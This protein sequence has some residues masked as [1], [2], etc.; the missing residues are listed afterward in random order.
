MQC[1]RL[2]F[3]VHSKQITLRNFIGN[4]KWDL[5]ACSL[6]WL[7]HVCVPR[8]IVRWLG[9]EGVVIGGCSISSTVLGTACCNGIVRAFILE[10][11]D[12]YG[13]C[14]ILWVDL[15]REDVPW[16]VGFIP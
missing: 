5:S 12:A 1:T 15:K 9:L 11:S 2:T 3:C 7:L 10:A 8:N 4:K 6:C 16:R 13:T 14:L